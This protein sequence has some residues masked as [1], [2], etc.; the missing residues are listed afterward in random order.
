MQRRW[1]LER[2]GQKKERQKQKLQ[3][4]KAAVRFQLSAMGTL[5]SLDQG[6]SELPIFTKK[7]SRRQLHRGQKN[8]KRKK[9]RST[10]RGGRAFAQ[11]LQK[12]QPQ[13][14]QL[15][16]SILFRARRKSSSGS[17]SSSKKKKVTLR[18]AEAAFPHNVMPWPSG[19]SVLG[20]QLI[21]WGEADSL[22]ELFAQT[23]RHKRKK[24]GTYTY[25]IILLSL[26]HQFA[27]VCQASY[28]MLLP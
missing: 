24:S 10:R 2:E 16:V 19:T 18:S 17:S 9:K 13:L 28:W 4:K 25:S 15:A 23:K 27:D 21:I 20:L 14:W 6:S 5:D 22:C 8:T 26:C 7:Q 1:L 3:V 11:S 12:P